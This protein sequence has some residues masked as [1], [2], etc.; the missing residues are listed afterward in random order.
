MAQERGSSLR[1]YDPA[2]MANAARRFPHVTMCAS[3]YEAAEGADAVVVVT[4]WREFRQVDLGRVRAAMRGD[5]LLDGRNLYD[6]Q[7]VAAAGLRYEGIGRGSLPRAEDA[8]APVAA[9][10]T[11]GVVAQVGVLVNGRETGG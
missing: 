8:V 4:P 9:G 11:N 10:V 6:P 1:A 2:A 3:L 7:N 5:L